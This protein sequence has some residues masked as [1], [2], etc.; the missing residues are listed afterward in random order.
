LPIVFHSLKRRAFWIVARTCF[1][2]YRTFPL[3]GTLRASIGILQRDDKFLVIH[4]NDGRGVSLPGG[5]S[6]WKETEEET[7]GREIREE[8]GLRVT[9][10]ELK[11]KYYSDAD[12]PCSISVFEVQAS[13][14]LQNSWEGSFRW[15]TL[16]E[17]EPR[18]VA[19]QR[20]VVEVM[21]RMVV[22]ATTFHS[23]TT[24]GEFNEK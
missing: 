7:L 21:K 20:P 16:A 5:I 18:L 13:G 17:L 3:F 9:G 1:A 11:L 6:G 19:S 2:L 4:R 23:G 14:D 10:Q 22:Q 8:T 24:H 12:V 15:N